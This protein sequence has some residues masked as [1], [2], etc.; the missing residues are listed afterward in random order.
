MMLCG[1]ALLAN[2]R[3]ILFFMSKRRMCQRKNKPSLVL[4]NISY[5][6][7]KNGKIGRHAKRPIKD[8]GE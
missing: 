1:T 7:F 5:T 2:D 4:R 6:V 8:L 3:S